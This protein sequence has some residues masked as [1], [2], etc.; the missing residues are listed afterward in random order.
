MEQANKKTVEFCVS[1]FFLSESACKREHRK[2]LSSL[3]LNKTAWM[4]KNKLFCL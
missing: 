3:L 4:R 2:F 1:I